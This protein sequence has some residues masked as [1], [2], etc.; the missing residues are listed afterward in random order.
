LER[1]QRIDYKLSMPK[2][3]KEEKEGSVEKDQKE[4]EYYY[5]DAHGYEEFDPELEEDES[6]DLE[7]KSGGE[8]PFRTCE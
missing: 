8:P 1:I 4:H 6:E 5:D 7:E 2:N 3:P